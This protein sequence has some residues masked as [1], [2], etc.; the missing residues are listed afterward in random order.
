MYK[1]PF[2][3]HIS[4]QAALAGRPDSSGR[5]VS[6]RSAFDFPGAWKG[7]FQSAF[8]FGDVAASGFRSAFDA[9]SD[10]GP[11]MSAFDF[12]GADPALSAFGSFEHGATVKSAFDFASD[13]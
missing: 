6:F 13:A 10:K 5:A 12:A 4:N 2:V 9:L 8:D 3:S 7:T 11:F 1:Q